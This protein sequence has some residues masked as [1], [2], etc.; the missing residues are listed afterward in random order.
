MRTSVP[1]ISC[2]LAAKASRNSAVLHSSARRLHLKLQS[3]QSIFALSERMQNEASQ[4]PSL[5][6]LLLDFSCHFGANLLIVP[7]SSS[8]LP[9]GTIQLQT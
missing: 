7:E 9:Q 4:T 6:N 3:R 8:D 5:T 2:K 1:P